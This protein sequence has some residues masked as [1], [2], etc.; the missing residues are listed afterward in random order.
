MLYSISSRVVW[1]IVDGRMV[2]LD[3]L[4]PCSES[5]S[6]VRFLGV[7]YWCLGCLRRFFFDFDFLYVIRY[8]SA[9]RGLGM[10]SAY[11]YE[12]KGVP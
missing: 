5:Y 12:K 8:F 3:W 9:G 4:V 10:H 1:V 2:S 7:S 11:R 6:A